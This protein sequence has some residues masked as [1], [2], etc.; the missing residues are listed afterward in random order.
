MLK[1]INSDQLFTASVLVI[2][3]M[4]MMLSGLLT[5]FDNIFYDIGLNVTAQNPPEDIV[6]VAIDARS[7]EAFGKWPWSRDIHANLIKKISK[8][9]PKAIGLDILFAEPDRVDPAHDQQLINAIQSAGN[10]VLPLV[11]EAPYQ[12]ASAKLHSSIPKMVQV[13]ASNGRVNV[14]LD[15]DGIARG[16]FLWAG[17]YSEYEKINILP[18]F[19]SSVLAVAG[20]LPI[21]FQDQPTFVKP[22]S[23]HQSVL[24]RT[25]Q[26]R[27][28]FYGPPDRFKQ[29]SYES[30]LLG[31]VPKDFFYQ[32]IVLVGATAVG[33][34]DI[35]PTPMSG[36]S[37]PMSGVEFNANVIAS[38]REGAMIKPIPIFLSLVVAVLMVLIPLLWLPNSKPLHALIL[39]VIYL[40]VLMIL[41]VLLPSVLNRWMPPSA[42]LLM[43]LLV[44][45]IWSWRRLD[46]A[47]AFLE[48]EFAR[49]NDDLV[50]Y[51]L[52]DINTKELTHL[53]AHH[54]NRY[55][56]L[57]TR[58]GQL[59]DA[60]KLLRDLQTSKQDTLAFISHDLR[61]PLLTASMML[62]APDFIENKDKILRILDQANVLADHFLNISKAQSLS[63][64]EF[65]ELELNSL[66][67]EV[68]D[69]LYSY[70]QSKKIRLKLEINDES[71]W[72]NGDF[73]LLHRALMNVINNAIKFS[74]V[75]QAVEIKL[76]QKLNQAVVAIT[77]Y[78]IGIPQDKLETVFKR[79]S[80]LQSSQRMIQGS[81]LGLYFVELTLKKHSGEISVKSEANQWTTFTIGIPLVEAAKA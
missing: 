27:V 2:G 70:A 71:L 69:Q 16:I 60:G 78:G 7:L 28:R 52:G 66:L 45:P 72:V 61:M 67:Q 77:D 37:K 12:G 65:K 75:G 42:I 57:Q 32:K 13:A 53:G 59:N 79:F 25:E 22:K 76:S 47:Y 46:R 4:I 34:G 33:M 73:S 39:I 49:L 81:G 17:I 50:Q 51:G 3:V 9:Q 20:M 15:N 68:V 1:I 62:K 41:A 23:R 30:V 74:H 58:I 36:F 35:L 64:V 38:M 54:L 80:R 18:H 14:P 11:I 8:D 48:L 63:V 29:V 43:I 31:E 6:I 5:R 40:F 44:Y 10:V 26:Q 24:L 55:D 21:G 56:L 19:S